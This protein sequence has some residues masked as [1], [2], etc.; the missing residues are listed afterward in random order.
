MISIFDTY[1]HTLDISLIANPA[2]AEG[3]FL[4]LPKIAGWLVDTESLA[5]T[6]APYDASSRQSLVP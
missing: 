2:L 6:A 5:I 3:V 4:V 1:L